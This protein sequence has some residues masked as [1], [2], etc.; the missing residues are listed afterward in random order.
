MLFDKIFLSRKTFVGVHIL[1]IVVCL[2]AGIES[3]I[4]GTHSLLIRIATATYT[5]GSSGILYALG[6]HAV[7]IEN[8]M[9]VLCLS[10]CNTVF[11]T[12]ILFFRFLI[13]FRAAHPFGVFYDGIPL[14][15]GA[16]FS[17]IAAV[18]IAY[19]R[20]CLV[21]GLVYPVF[22]Q[23]RKKI[24]SRVVFVRREYPEIFSVQ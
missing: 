9:H 11:L 22:M 10:V 12:M 19:V 14:I 21:N 3:L 16:S 8:M 17:L 1:Y 4:R 18:Y 23:R 6:I 2:A 20:R 5:F 13:E 24:E 15:I 7:G